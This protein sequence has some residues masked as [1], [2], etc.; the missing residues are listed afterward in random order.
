MVRKKKLIWWESEP[1]VTSAE[2]ARAR[3]PQVD[4]GHPRHP[5]SPYYGPVTIPWES[6]PDDDTVGLVVG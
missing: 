1:T 4:S 6:D 2:H 5:R 3:G